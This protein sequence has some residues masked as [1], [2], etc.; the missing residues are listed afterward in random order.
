MVVVGGVL[1]WF[2]LY[3]QNSILQIAFPHSNIHAQGWHAGLLFS[4]FSDAGKHTHTHIQPWQ[5]RSRSDNTRER[6]AE[7]TLPSRQRERERARNNINTSCLCVPLESRI[8]RG[9][10][11]VILQVERQPA[12]GRKR[13][14]FCFIAMYGKSKNATVPSDAQAREKWVYIINNTCTLTHTHKSSLLLT[15]SFTKQI[16]QHIYINVLNMEEREKCQFANKTG[17]AMLYNVA[18]VTHLP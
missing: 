9:A 15:I 1:R 3:W 17:F 2:A 10:I 11:S 6:E 14:Y 7:K 5:V 16:K 4:P 8:L 18:M 12:P 13:N